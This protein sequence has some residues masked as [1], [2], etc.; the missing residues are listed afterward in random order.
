MLCDRCTNFSAS[1]IQTFKFPSTKNSKALEFK[2]FLKYSNRKVHWKSKIY[3]VSTRI[4]ILHNTRYT[5]DHIYLAQ[6]NNIQIII[7]C[8]ENR[9]DRSYNLIKKVKDLSQDLR[10]NDLIVLNFF[11]KE[12]G[13]CKIHSKVLHMQR[14]IVPKM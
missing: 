3:E 5:K 13:P 9:I 4:I 12:W 6:N 11:S 10:V 1:D 7:F 2:Q 14:S 8:C